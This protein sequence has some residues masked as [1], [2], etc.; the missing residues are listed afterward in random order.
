MRVY[1]PRN[2]IKYAEP[3]QQKNVKSQ[4]KAGLIS[5]I[6]KSIFNKWRGYFVAKIRLKSKQDAEN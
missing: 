3:K 2:L 5:I 4:I 1:C 6:L